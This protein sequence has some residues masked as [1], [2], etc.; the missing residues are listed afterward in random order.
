MARFLVVALCLVKEVQC[1]VVA[2][3]VP[4][5]AALVLAVAVDKKCFFIEIQNKSRY[6]VLLYQNFS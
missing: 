5:V 4:V 1:L 3:L 2:A 6:K